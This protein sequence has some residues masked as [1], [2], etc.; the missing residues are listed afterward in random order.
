MKTTNAT[1]QKVLQIT[2]DK[3][4]V[5]QNILNNN[6]SFSDDLGAD[7]LDVYELIMS[8]EKEFKITIDDDD[9]AKLTTVGAMINY[10]DNKTNVAKNAVPSQQQEVVIN[11]KLKDDITNKSLLKVSAN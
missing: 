8:I 2:A 11:D 10:I 1:T 9:A 5:H 6:T 3:L 7:S 4:G